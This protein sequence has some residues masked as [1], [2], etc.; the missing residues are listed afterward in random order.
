[1]VN[2]DLNVGRVEIIYL[3]YTDVVGMGDILNDDLSCLLK[4]DVIFPDI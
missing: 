1:M 4:W 2:W 3:V